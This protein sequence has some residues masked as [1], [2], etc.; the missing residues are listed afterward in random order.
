MNKK[1]NTVIF[2]LVATLLNLVLLA[3]FGLA[4]FLFFAF[5]Y[6]NQQEANSALSWI[7]VLVTMFGSIG[8]GYFVYSKL[9][10]WAIDKW[11]LEN[12][13]EPIFRPRRR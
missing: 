13:I 6:R 3:A 7:A 2:M 10:K 4:F 1:L 11:N 8:C 12:Y 5:I 9:V